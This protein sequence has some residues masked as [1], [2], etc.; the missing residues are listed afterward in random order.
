M[1][2]ERMAIIRGVLNSIRIFNK[3][4]KIKDTEINLLISFGREENITL[5]EATEF[6]SMEKAA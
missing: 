3:M 5:Q 6:L 1:S 4:W 2:E